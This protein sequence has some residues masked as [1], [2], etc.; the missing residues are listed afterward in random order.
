[1]EGR[2]Y[3]DSCTCLFVNDTPM[4]KTRMHE[5]E[6]NAHI[7][8]IGISYDTFGDRASRGRIYPFCGGIYERYHRLDARDRSSRTGLRLACYD[9]VRLSTISSH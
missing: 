4:F 6:M 2:D 5:I 7:N 3:I 8:G 1:M 9:C